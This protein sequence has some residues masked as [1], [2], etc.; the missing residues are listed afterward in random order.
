MEIINISILWGKICWGKGW[1]IGIL[2]ENGC[3]IIEIGAGRGLFTFF[4]VGC[5]RVRG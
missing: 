3:E 2:V 4:W 1:E 5:V